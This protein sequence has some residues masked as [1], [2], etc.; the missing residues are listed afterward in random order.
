MAAML[1]ALDEKQLINYIREEVGKK[2]KVR[3]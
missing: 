1:S 3:E 2:D